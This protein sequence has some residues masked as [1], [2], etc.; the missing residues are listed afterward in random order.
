MGD[1]HKLVLTLTHVVFM[2]LCG[3]DLPTNATSA[4]ED[5]TCPDCLRLM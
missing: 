3:I 5:V 1:V 4:S 2:S